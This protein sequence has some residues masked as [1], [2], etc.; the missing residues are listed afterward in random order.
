MAKAQLISLPCGAGLRSDDELMLL[1]A[2]GRRQAFEALVRR[3]QAKALRIAGKL[4][5]Q[6]SLAQD[7]VQNAFVEL[8][9]VLPD[10]RAQGKFTSYLYRVL[11][12][13]CRMAGRARRSVERTETELQRTLLHE[14][15]PLSADELLAWERQRALDA[16][17]RQLSS[18]LSAVL[19]LRYA[20]D[21]SHEEIAE[22]LELPLGTVKSRLA[23]GLKKMREMLGDERP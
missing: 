18:T 19:V 10:Y 4:L 8:Y 11:L 2:G 6:S 14:A 7:V 21:L 15:A 12:N 16:C 20:A 23:Q 5:G 13:Q 22:T 1:A 3:H 9:R 17:L